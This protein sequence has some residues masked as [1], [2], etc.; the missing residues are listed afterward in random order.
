MIRLF[1]GIELLPSLLGSLGLARGGVE[2]ARWQ[3]DEQLHLTLAF[4]GTVPVHTMREIE[5]ELSRIRFNPFELTLEGVG[6][7]GTTDQPKALWAGVADGTPLLHLHEKILNTLEQID[8]T[9]DRRR[10]KPHVTLARFA[11]GTKTC[12]GDWVTSNG[13]LKSPPQ[14]VDHFSLFSSTQTSEGP[15]YIAEARFAGSEEWQD[16]TEDDF[17]LF[18]GHSK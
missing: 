1:V 4:I 7:F 13:T 17:A 16:H 18:G 3:S 12:F 10:Y 14:I 5:D 8:V 6:M 2:G 11:R 15:S 9:V